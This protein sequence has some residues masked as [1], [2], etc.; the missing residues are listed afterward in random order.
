MSQHRSQTRKE[1]MAEIIS[2]MKAAKDRGQD[3]WSAAK[4]AFPGIPTFVLAEAL[5][6]FDASEAEA[7]WETVERTIDGEIIRNALAK[8][9][10]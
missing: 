10:E 2:T 9:G 6:E 3:E 1:V 8:A 5:A 4:R 7:W